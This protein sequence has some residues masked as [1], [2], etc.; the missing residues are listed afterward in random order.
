MIGCALGVPM[1]ESRR[2]VVLRS[3]RAASRRASAAAL[4][5]T[6]AREWVSRGAA[7]RGGYAV[8]DATRGHLRVTWVISSPMWRRLGP[9]L[10]VV[11]C[12]VFVVLGASCGDG[13]PSFTKDEQ[14]AQRLLGGFVASVFRGR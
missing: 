5:K 8:G 13:R 11:G 7:R 10:E 6:R 14:Y 2:A 3:A 12:V 9:A 1:D 4:A